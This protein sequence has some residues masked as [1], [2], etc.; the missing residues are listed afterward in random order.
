LF[1]NTIIS[2]I[3]LQERFR[4]YQIKLQ[5]RFRECQIKLQERFREF[6]YTPS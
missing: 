2:Q 3:K 4:E 6:I 1:V 5:E